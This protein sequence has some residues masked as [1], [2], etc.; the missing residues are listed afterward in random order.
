MCVSAALCKVGVTE[1]MFAA[2]TYALGS[3]CYA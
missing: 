1:V 3:A 2:I